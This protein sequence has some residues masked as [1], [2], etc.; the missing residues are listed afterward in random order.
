MAQGKR[1]TATLTARDLK[2]VRTAL[3]KVGGSW[4]KLHRAVEGSPRRRP[5][6]PPSD[7]FNDISVTQTPW[8]GVFCVKLRIAGAAPLVAAFVRRKRDSAKPWTGAEEK[9]GRFLTPTQFVES[10]VKAVREGRKGRLPAGLYAT[11]GAIKKGLYRRLR[12][13]GL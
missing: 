8:K 5:G 3:N 2:N 10:V 12:A 13:A 9:A 7:F 11:E 1:R 6:R 4:E